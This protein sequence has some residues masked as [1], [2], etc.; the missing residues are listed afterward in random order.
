MRLTQSGEIE[1]RVQSQALSGL[2]DELERRF[3]HVEG[4][5]IERKG[6]VLAIHTRAAPHALEAINLAVEEV[7]EEMTEGHH[8]MLGNAGIEVLPVGALKSVAIER[9]MKVEPFARRMP[10]FIGDDISDESGFRFVNAI[11]GVSVRVFPKGET[12]ANY[13][14]KDVAATRRW[15]AALIS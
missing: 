5:H 14:L 1:R 8:I 15:L 3:G 11:G 12:D 6:A 9:F 7:L 10:V 2:A 4:I 13:V